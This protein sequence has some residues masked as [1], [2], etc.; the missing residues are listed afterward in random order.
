MALPKGSWEGSITTEKNICYLCR[1]K[2]LLL[3]EAL[4]ARAPGSER[5]PQPRA[6]EHVVF[7]SHFERGFGLPA[8]LFFRSFLDF[9]GLQPHH[10]GANAV[11][12]V[13][14]FSTL[15]EGYLGMLLTMELWAKMFFLKQH[16]ASA[17]AM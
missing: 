14:G 8:S 4:L 2:R 7:Y 5:V 15:C 1:M 16:G 6:G 13:T 10:L 17:G 12:Q 9:F 11:L 3:V